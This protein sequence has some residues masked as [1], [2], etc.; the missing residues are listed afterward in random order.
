MQASTYAKGHSTLENRQGFLLLIF[1]SRE[2]NKEKWNPN[3]FLTPT[4]LSASYISMVSVGSADVPPLSHLHA[5][6]SKLLHDLRRL[7]IL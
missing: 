7:L 2:K 6:G 5:F 4:T 1:F 3:R